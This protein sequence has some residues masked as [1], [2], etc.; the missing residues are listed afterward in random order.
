MLVGFMTEALGGMLCHLKLDR[1]EL[2]RLIHREPGI[3]LADV[4]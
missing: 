3:G 4:A 1:F 2:A